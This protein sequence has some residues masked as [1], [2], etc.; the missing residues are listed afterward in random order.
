MRAPQPKLSAAEDDAP[1]SRGNI[2]TSA[3][4]EAGALIRLVA[5]PSTA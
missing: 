2:G 3:T 5:R 1:A 4:G